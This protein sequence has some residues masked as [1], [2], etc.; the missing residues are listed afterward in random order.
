[1]EGAA[2][3]GG[4]LGAGGA[5]TVKRDGGNARQARQDG[6]ADVLRT[7]EARVIDCSKSQDGIVGRR[8]E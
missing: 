7:A 3:K 5:A 1:M 6:R 4:R 2:T 8:N